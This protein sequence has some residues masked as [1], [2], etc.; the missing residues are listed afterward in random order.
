MVSRR[1][2][3]RLSVYRRALAGLPKTMPF[4]FSRQ[5]AELSGASAAQVRRDLMVLSSTGSPSRGYCVA[6]LIRSIDAFFA[7]GSRHKVALVGL[8]TLGRAL[9]AFFQ[10]RYHRFSILAIFDKDPEQTGRVVHGIRSYPMREL[11]R[12][13]EEAGISIAVLAL[14]DGT[15]QE[16]ADLLTQAGVT[17]LLNFAPVTLRVPEGVSVE[18]IDIPAALDRLAFFAAQ[19]KIFYD[20][21]EEVTHAH[22]DRE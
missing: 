9:I 3:K 7:G 19:E 20:H 15:A 8:G 22:P 5:L 14:P 13:V 17:G 18:N 2:I 16:V 1:S 6:D 12:V 10:R 11:P 4:I 21:P